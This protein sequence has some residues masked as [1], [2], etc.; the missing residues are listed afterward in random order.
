MVIIVL[1]DELN[2]YYFTPSVNGR[3]LWVGIMIFQHGWHNDV[4]DIIEV[5]WNLIQKHG[6]D[7]PCGRNG[8][9]LDMEKQ[10]AP[11]IILNQS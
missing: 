7:I 11:F 1:K 8:D 6:N 5:F 10:G 9:C 3:Y 2:Q 4:V